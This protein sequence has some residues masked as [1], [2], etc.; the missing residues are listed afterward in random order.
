M[1]QSGNLIPFLTAAEN[2]ELAIELGGR[3]PAR[4]ARAR[5]LLA[6]LGLADRARPPAPPDVGRRGAARLGRDGAR[7]RARPAARRRGDGRARLGE[8]RRRS[9]RSS[10]TPG[11]TRGLTVLFVTHSRRARR[12]RPAPAA[13]R[14]RRGARRHERGRAGDRRSSGVTKHYATPAGLVRAVDG[15]T[16]DV[17][18]GHQPRRSPGRAAAGS[19]R[20]SA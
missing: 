19:R 8:R 2:V 20:C 6:E 12:P 17:R 4:A 13:A 1:L 7:Q 10:S 11:A 16:L 5:A 18:A 15:I 14:R 9:W 3:R